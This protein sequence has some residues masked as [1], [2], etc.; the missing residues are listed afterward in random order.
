MKKL[1]LL[2]LSLFISLISS[3]Y[4]QTFEE[5]K[6]I[7]KYIEF[8]LTEVNNWTPTSNAGYVTIYNHWF[9]ND[10]YHVDKVK[11]ADQ[12]KGVLHFNADADVFFKGL[13]KSYSCNYDNL[14]KNIY[15]PKELSSN[16]FDIANTNILINYLLKEYKDFCNAQSTKVEEVKEE[17]ATKEIEVYTVVEKNAEYKGG[18]NELYAFINKNLVYPDSARNNGISGKV[19]TKFIIN[20]NGGVEEVQIVKGILNCKKCDEEAIRVLKLTSGKWNPAEIQS[21]KVKVYYSLPIAF[22]L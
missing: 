15:V 20:E 13:L 11:L 18:T 14:Q 7:K 1:K 2:I 12:L 4:S 3:C 19:F 8:C 6:A 16:S 21:K 9:A 22:K 17:K 10:A 5:K